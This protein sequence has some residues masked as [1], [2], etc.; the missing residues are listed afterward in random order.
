MS[1][2]REFVA[3][4]RRMFQLWLR[5]LPRV[6]TW[7]LLSWLLYGLCLMGSAL[8]GN[9]FGV[10]GPLLFVV[11]VT[12]NV[13]GVVFAIHELKPGLT[14][15]ERIRA[16]GHSDLNHIPEAVWARERRVDVAVL[17]IGPVLG[18]Y[19]VW[20]LI[21]DMI[22][23]G[24]LW[25]TVIQTVWNASEWSIN[26]HPDRLPTYLALGV[27]ALAGKSLYGWLVRRRASSWWRVPLIFLEG[28]WA[29][30]TFFIILLGA[31]SVLVWLQQRRIWRD[32]E[33]AWHQFLEWLPD[34][35]LPFDLTLPEALNR[36]GIWLAESVL[37][38]LWEGVALP[39][40]WLSVVAI[41]F[42]WREFR[43]RDLLGK[44]ARIRSRLVDNA[45]DDVAATLGRLF[46]LLFA[47]LRDKY[48]PLLHAFRLIWKSGPY[49]LGAYLILSALVSA[50][51]VAIQGALFRVFA[52]DTA[53]NAL[54]AFNGIEAWREFVFVSLSVCLYAAAFDR[55]L[56]D[57][58][59]LVDAGR[60]TDP[61][62]PEPQ[63]SAAPQSEL[64]EGPSPAG[65]KI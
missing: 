40:M 30:A 55:G 20:G 13:V 54:R 59:G 53:E 65:V 52:A 37:P 17:T 8:L 9:R 63:L 47:D 1:L 38:G 21:D 43:A 28:L 42:G 51:T 32:S 64:K 15:A 62:E 48:L 18:V 50:I 23:D 5:F 2:I 44:N 39:L 6:G 16:R 41:V 12:F 22:R 25:N 3:L 56:A 36:A 11:G 31:E 57:A 46:N 29:F 45:D 58:S 61:H 49:V 34:L 19:A 26:R 35:R 27:A 4:A 10:V 7:L 60:D 33:T 14:S 24:F